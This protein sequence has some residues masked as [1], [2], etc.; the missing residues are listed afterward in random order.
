ML[1]EEY[2]AAQKEM[3]RNEV[4]RVAFPAIVIRSRARSY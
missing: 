2:I 3:I 1:K 4:E